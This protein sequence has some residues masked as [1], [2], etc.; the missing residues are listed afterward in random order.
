MQLP[1]LI[2][3]DILDYVMSF[4]REDLGDGAL[5]PAQLVVDLLGGPDDENRKLYCRQLEAWYQEYASGRGLAFKQPGFVSCW[6]DF[7][8]K[9][10]VCP[11]KDFDSLLSW[12][13]WLFDKRSLGTGLQ[14]R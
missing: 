7:I 2:L 12:M 13:G 8:K 11:P 9:K 5:H 6:R 3:Q 1:N 14:P 4:R 10:F